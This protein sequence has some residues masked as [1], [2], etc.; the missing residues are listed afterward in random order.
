MWRTSTKIF[1]LVGTFLLFTVDVTTAAEVTVHAVVVNPK[2]FDHQT[3]TLQGTAAAVKET[4]SHRGNAYT[5]FKL[6]DPSS[7]DSISIFT[8]GH[9]PLTNGDHV[10]VDGTF[11]TVHRQGQYT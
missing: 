1:A 10:R 5:T 11:E 6:Q 3:L 8:W 9:P 4:T 7:S 2:S